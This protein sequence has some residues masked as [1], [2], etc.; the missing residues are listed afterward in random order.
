MPPTALGLPAM[1]T[2]S[3]GADQLSAPASAH[4]M[5]SLTSP[6]TGFPPDPPGSAERVAQAGR[7]RVEQMH[8][9]HQR[10]VRGGHGLHTPPQD[11]GQRVV[12]VRKT[13][14]VRIWHT[15]TEQAGRVLCITIR[16]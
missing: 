6:A 10:H 3:H 7:Q 4:A 12:H 2:H 13:A 9:R 14:S 5:P 15:K 8:A 16:P 11:E 1:S